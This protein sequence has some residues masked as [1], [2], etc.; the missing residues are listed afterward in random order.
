MLCVFFVHQKQFFSGGEGLEAPCLVVAPL[1]V[2]FVFSCAYLER[3]E[4]TE[5]EE[6]RA[7]DDERR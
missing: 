2:L 6:S 3:R 1:F 5:G 7:I 4:E